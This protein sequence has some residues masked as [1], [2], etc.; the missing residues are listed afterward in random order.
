MNQRDIAI[1]KTVKW[2][3]LKHRNPSKEVPMQQQPYRESSHALFECPSETSL[4]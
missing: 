2:N 1:N 4:Q 3:D